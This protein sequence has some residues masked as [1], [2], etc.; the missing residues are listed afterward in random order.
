MKFANAYLAKGKR[1]PGYNCNLTTVRDYS[2]VTAACMMMRR[3]VFTKMRGFDEKFVVGFNDTDLCLRIGEA[4]FKVLYDGFT[5]L[6]HH[7]SAT[8][9]ESKEVDHPEDD[10]RLRVR[11]S[12]FF[13]RGDP[14][15][16]PLLAPRGTD[17]TLRADAGCKGRMGVRVVS[18]SGGAIR[19]DPGRKET[20][21]RRKTRAGRASLAL[22][23]EAAE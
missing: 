4:G 21:V 9:T 10:A 14:F 7:E 16:S 18:M 3:S 17:H 20:V 22:S 11:W 19:T 15:Y 8:R 23:T 6:Y 13:T 1:H 12:Q 5:V 2:A